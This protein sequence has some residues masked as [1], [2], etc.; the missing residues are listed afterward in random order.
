MSREGGKGGRETVGKSIMHAMCI[1]PVYAIYIDRGQMQVIKRNILYTL[2]KVREP[3][4]SRIYTV[5]DSIY[6]PLGC[7]YIYI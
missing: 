1:W 6:R 3:Y 5:D 7:V 2:Y 4:R